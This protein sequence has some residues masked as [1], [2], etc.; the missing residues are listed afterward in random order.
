MKKILCALLLIT[1]LLTAAS[2]SEKSV[3]YKDT[4]SSSELAALISSDLKNASNMSEVDDFYIETT[5]GIDVTKA[6]SHFVAIQ[7]G[8][9]EL[10]E[11][12]I[13]KM[14][15]EIEASKMK[16]DLETYLKNRV[17]NYDTRYYIEELPKFEKAE[18]KAYGKYVI[19]AVLADTER[20]TIFKSAEDALK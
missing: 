2:C 9:T 20:P 11:Y 4:L 10:D 14:P 5:L 18:V 8:G 12:G 19:Y 17:D 13:F 16:T 3:S 15:D 7:T 1:I 6:D